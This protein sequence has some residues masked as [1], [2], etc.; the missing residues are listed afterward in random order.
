VPLATTDEQTSAANLHTLRWENFIKPENPTKVHKS[1]AQSA[2]EL[3]LQ[4]QNLSD[5][6]LWVMLFSYYEKWAIHSSHF[7]ICLFLH[8][9]NFRGAQ[10]QDPSSSSPTTIAFVCSLAT[11]LLAV[12]RFE[13]SLSSW[14][15]LRI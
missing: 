5:E 7:A 1:T 15:D 12:V 3:E 4:T 10:A 9:A 14:A 13:S 2:R 6:R 11:R 8:S